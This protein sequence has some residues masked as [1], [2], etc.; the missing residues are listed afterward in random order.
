VDIYDASMTALATNVT[1]TR[2]D[3]SSYSTSAS[4]P[5]AAWVQITGSAK[6]YVNDADPKGDYTIDEW[7]SDF[8]SFGEYGRLTGI[9][10]CSGTQVARPT[11]NA[12][13]GPISDATQFASF[14]QAQCCLPFKPCAPRVIAI[15]PNSEVFPNGITYDFPE[16]FIA[17]ETYGSKWWKLPQTTMTDLFWQ[18]PHRPCHIE[19]CALWKQDNGE[20]DHDSD[21][22]CPPTEDTPAPEY[23]YGYYPLV[24]ARLTVPSVADVCGHAYGALQDEAG[25]ALP[26]GI[27][28][29][30]L[31]P[32]DHDTGDV[33]LP[34]KPGGPNSG[35]GVPLAVDT[36]WGLHKRFC[37]A[38]P[39][40]FNYPRL[41][42]DS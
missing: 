26:T 1:A 16:T 9:L 31:S 39:C 18:Q 41:N 33:A 4:Y 20:C 14:S 3:D 24:E 36:A 40:R 22:V 25:P 5:T 29:G 23:F 2:I 35:N 21:G 7:K 17:D 38:G 8:R 10:D 28:I 12:G 34:P 13:G 15:S 30:W 27:E 32:V 19:P 37:D 42:C 11:T 6:W